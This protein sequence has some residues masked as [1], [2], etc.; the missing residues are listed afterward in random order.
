MILQFGS[1]T[2]VMLNRLDEA[3]KS[4]F[5]LDADQTFEWKNLRVTTTHV[6]H[7]MKSQLEVRHVI[8]EKVGSASLRLTHYSYLNWPE[9]R[10]ITA[11]QLLD[12]IETIR[13]NEEKF[14]SPIVVH[15]R[16]GTGRTG[17]FI[18]MNII[19]DLINESDDLSMLTLDLMGIVHRL[20]LDRTK[21]VEREV[22]RRR[23][24]RIDASFSSCRSFRMNICCSI[25][26][27]TN[28]YNASLGRKLVK[29]HL[30]SIESLP[31]IRAYLQTS[32]QSKR[33]TFVWKTKR[34]NR[35]KF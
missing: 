11:P 14:S 28:M 29:N 4:Y 23:T 27:S 34:R 18:A 8:V 22:S 33:R 26:V 3:S 1:T 16:L 32:P 35:R 15:C 7:R 19:I 17:T 24:H 5:P 6:E 9:N 30:I 31:M 20:R 25:V 21:L 2:I 10:S 12:L 13:P